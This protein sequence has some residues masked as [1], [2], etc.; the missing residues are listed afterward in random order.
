MTIV[1][2]RVLLVASIV[3]LPAIGCDRTPEPKSKAQAEPKPPASVEPVEQDTSYRHTTAGRVVAI[4]D[5]HGDLEAT[6]RVLRLAG[7]MN[8]QGSW[9]GG[10]S[11]LVQTGDVLDRGDGEREIMDLL[12]RL[13]EQAEKAGGAVHLLNGNHEVMNVAGDFRYVT[14]GGFTSF[15]NVDASKAPTAGFPPHAR[16][17]A[18]AFLPGGPFAVRLARNDTVVMV[19][20]SLFVHGGV[21]PKHLRYGLGRINREMKAWMRGEAATPPR[22]MTADDAPIWT[23]RFSSPDVSASDCRMLRL[24]LERAGA[25]RMVVGHTVQEGRIT[26]AC[27]DRVWRIDVGLASHYGSAPA[28]ALQI[29]GG[30]V[31]VLTAT[32]ER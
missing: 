29:E 22:V 31:N 3:L 23:R 21:L 19:G 26:S 1:T 15:E 24:V 14:R 16:G 13:R 5:L 32:A 11:V 28:S 7:V 27:E 20:D 17:R 12:D 18:A 9:S 30:K 25:K 8:E 4:G 2:R 6:K 10:K